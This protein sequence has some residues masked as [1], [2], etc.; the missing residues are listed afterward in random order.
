MTIGYFW[1]TLLYVCRYVLKEKRDGKYIDINN[2]TWDN[3]S[4]NNP[5]ENEKNRF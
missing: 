4:E 2:R 1:N 3:F 5:L